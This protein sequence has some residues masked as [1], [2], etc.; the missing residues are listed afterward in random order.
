M[1]EVYVCMAQKLTQL[2]YCDSTQHVILKNNVMQAEDQSRVGND[3]WEYTNA[4]KY[5]RWDF[6]PLSR[7]LT[8]SP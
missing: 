3:A 1:K 6:S 2:R 7:S 4:P 5:G 8:I